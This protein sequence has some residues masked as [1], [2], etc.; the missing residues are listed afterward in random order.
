MGL[1]SLYEKYMYGTPGMGEG[2]QGLFGQ[3]GQQ[4]G[5]LIDFNKMNNQQGGL[6]QNIP[7]TALLGSAIFGQGIQGKDPFSALLPAVTQTA[8]LQKLMTPKKGFKILSEEEAKKIPNYNPKKTYQ[9][10]M[11]TKQVS[12]IGGGDTTFNMSNPAEVPLKIRKQYIDESK[13]FIE[14]KNSRDAIL[15]NTQVEFDKRS[16]ADDFTL[17]YKYYKF[18]DPGSVVKE[19]EFDNLQKIG[20]I[21]DKIN[22]IIPKW[23]KGTELTKKQVSDLET[24][25]ERE[26]PT[27]LKNQKTRENTYSKIFS[28]SGYNIDTYLQS[29]LDDKSPASVKKSNTR[30]YRNASTQELIRRLN[31]MDQ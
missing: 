10:N 16:P 27:Y 6:L 2:T 22:R 30:K 19:S 21:G 14:R 13:N 11:E 7:Q 18:V 8:Q 28:D 23:T 17:V 1:R 15:S 9:Q 31:E 4:S 29:F 25:M 12:V 26:Y 20:S 5:G 3:G 24:A